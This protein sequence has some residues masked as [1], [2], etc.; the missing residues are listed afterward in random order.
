MLTKKEIHKRL[1]I[2]YKKFVAYDVQNGM[3][4]SYNYFIFYIKNCHCEL[5]GTSMKRKLFIPFSVI[6]LFHFILP[7]NTSA[8]YFKK[9]KT[10]FIFLLHC[11]LPET[12][13]SSIQLFSS[14]SCLFLRLSINTQF[15]TLQHPIFL[16]RNKN[17]I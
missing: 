1:I 6:S 15:G 16:A 8:T 9:Y 2:L 7:R 13:P 11:F 10:T 17:H 5:L 12:S 14:I 3:M 4:E